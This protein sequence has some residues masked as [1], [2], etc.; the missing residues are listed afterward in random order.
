MRV[1]APLSNTEALF[2]HCEPRVM[3]NADAENTIKSGSRSETIRFAVRTG[4]SPR[5]VGPGLRGRADYD[6]AV[7]NAPQS[8]SRSNFAAAFCQAL[9]DRP[10]Q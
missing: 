3:D 10:S 4:R 2:Q 1:V 6:P 8:F 5:V 9:L 7:I